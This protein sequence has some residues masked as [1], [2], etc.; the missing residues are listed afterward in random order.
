MR[1]GKVMNGVQVRAYAEAVEIWEAY[2][3]GARLFR[4]QVFNYDNKEDWRAEVDKQADRFISIV[5]PT[6]PKDIT[7]I[8]DLH[9]TPGDWNVDGTEVRN[10]VLDYWQTTTG[11]L[12]NYE[13]V[14]YGVLNEPKGKVVNVNLLMNEALQRIRQ[15]EK[16][17]AIKAKIVCV[18]T[19]A[20]NPTMFNKLKVFSDALVWYE[21]H[22]YSPMKFTH[23]QIPNGEYPAPCKLTAQLLERLKKDLAT[24]YAFRKKYP[25]KPI[26]IGEFGCVD[27][28][29]EAD[30]AMWYRTCYQHWNRLK[31]HSCLHAWREW[32]HWQ[33]SGACLEVVKNNLK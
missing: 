6:L 12:K 29:T 30:R 31:A 1:V 17:L 19:P 28:A 16:N 3:L 23:Q 24:V 7:I 2:N 26:F 27:F 21:C 25:T 15:T 9:D 18:T 13:N 32:E 14:H 10:A 33:P 5:Y 20:A 11:K 8:L 22:V 4:F